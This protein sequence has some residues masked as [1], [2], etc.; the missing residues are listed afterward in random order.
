MSLFILSDP[1]RAAKRKKRPA[2]RK[3]VLSDHVTDIQD[4]SRGA[5]AQPMEPT[6]V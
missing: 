1:V 3:S 4:P 5:A 6:V 2:P